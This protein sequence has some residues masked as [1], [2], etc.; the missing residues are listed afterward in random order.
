MKL[1][2]TRQAYYDAT[3]KA[4]DITRQL[5]LAAI[6]IVWIFKIDQ[7]K[8]AMAVPHALL[9]PSVLAIAALSFDLL[10]YVYRSAAWG[11]F[12]RY[13]ELKTNLNEEAEFEAP[14]GLNWPS[15]AFFVLKLIAVGACYVGLFKYLFWKI[16]YQG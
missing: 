5:A 12:N 11:I 15:L 14:T 3:G 13:K 8:G 2:D 16:S 6:A 10:Q 7:P 1:E 4:S 9:W